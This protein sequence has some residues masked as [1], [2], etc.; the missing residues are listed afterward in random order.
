MHHSKQY[1]N[2]TESDI[3]FYEVLFDFD[4]LA[5]G[6]SIDDEPYCCYYNKGTYKKNL[7]LMKKKKNTIVHLVEEFE[8][9]ALVRM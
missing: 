7:K 1:V 5:L 4:G 6:I 3:D 9:Y 8:L 2:T